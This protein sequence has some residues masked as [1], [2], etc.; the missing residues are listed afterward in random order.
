MGLRKQNFRI[1]TVTFGGFDSKNPL[2]SIGDINL[3]VDS[4]EYNI[5]EMVHH[6]WLVAI[7]D[8]ISNLNKETG[9]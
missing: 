2:R 7:V 9:I 8:Y 6:I 1:K 4:S 5:V 3:W